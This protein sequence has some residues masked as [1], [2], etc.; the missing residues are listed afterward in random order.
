MAKQRICSI[1]N[2][3]KDART[4]G[5]CEKHYRQLLGTGERVNVP[6]RKYVTC[7]VEG[8]SNPH[9]TK[10]LCAKHNAQRKT[11]DTQKSRM[12]PNQSE[13]L[14]AWA[15]GSEI[16]YCILWPSWHGSSQYAM[17]KRGNKRW[18]AHRYVCTEAHGVA[19]A[20]MHACHACGNRRCIN[21]R[22]LYWGTPTENQADRLLHGTDGR[23]AKNPFAKFTDDQIR[24]I[25]AVPYIKH[26]K[27]GVTV[28]L[29]K[30]FGVT[31][32][33]I[34]SVRAGKTWRHL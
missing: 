23:G 34:S 28:S 31:P 5:L 3:G 21:P 20:G 14:V 32:G 6:P 24:E 13:Q 1:L 8:C 9:L 19:P 10:G 15:I 7:S 30:K 29:A 26:Q 4:R 33:A 2:C 22:H 17:L 27:S 12:T 25:R 18:P 16:D 11:K